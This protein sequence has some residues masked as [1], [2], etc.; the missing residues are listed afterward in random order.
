MKTVPCFFVR[1]SEIPFL[2]GYSRFPILGSTKKQYIYI[3]IIIVLAYSLCHTC[4]IFDVIMLAS[5]NRIGYFLSYVSISL[6]FMLKNVDEK[7]V[8]FA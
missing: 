3:Y 8:P 1:I 7:S 5:Y 2:S 6:R 4:I